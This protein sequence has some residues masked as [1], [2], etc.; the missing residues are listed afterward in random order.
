M[1]DFERVTEVKKYLGYTFNEMANKLGVNRNTFSDI[2]NGKCKISVPLSEKMQDL[3]QVN[4]RWL[5]TGEGEMLMNSSNTYN[6]VLGDNNGNATQN[7]NDNIISKII[8]ATNKQLEIKDAQL[9]KKD[10]QIDRLLSLL[11]KK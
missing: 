10:E 5:R 6:N 8:A 1:T 3:F 9:A 2:K 7:I 4:A 11:E